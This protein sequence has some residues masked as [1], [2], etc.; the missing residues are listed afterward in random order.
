MLILVILVA[1]MLVA[2]GVALPIVRPIRRATR[3]ITSTTD[4]V[5]QLANDA[6]RIAQEHGLGMSI[7]SGANKRFTGRRQSIIRDSQLIQ[8]ICTTLWPRMGT[9]QQI[10]QGRQSSQPQE[11]LQILQ[12]FAQ[13]MR[14]IYELALSIGDGLQKDNTFSQLGRAME[15]AQEISEPTVSHSSF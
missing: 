9:L 8:Q 1:V 14:Q 4:E 15:S 3:K 13:G 6:R 11:A 7:L 5:R 10:L 12:S 2:T